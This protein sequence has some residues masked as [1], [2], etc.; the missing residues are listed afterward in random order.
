VTLA[1]RLLA[2][3][4]LA[5]LA[6]LAPAG[7]AH[8][9]GTFPSA[10]WESTPPR[11]ARERALIVWDSGTKRE[12]FVREL[13][14]SHAA[15]RFGFVIPTPSRPTVH[16][17]EKPPFDG[18][19]TS[20]PSKLFPELGFGA[21]LRLGGAGR[22]A[23]APDPPVKVLEATR[24]GDFTAFV[25][26]ATDSGALAL[27]LKKHGF[28][29]SAARQLWTDAYVRLGF[30][31][32]ALR[33]EGTKDEDQKIVSRTLRLSFD[34]PLPYYPYRE[35]G[36]APGEPGRE[37]SLWTISDV[38]LVPYAGVTHQSEWRLR[39]PFSEGVRRFPSV[40][41]LAPTLGQELGG[42]L[43]KTRIVQT[44]GD[45]KPDRRGWE[46]VVFAPLGDCS[47]AC[48]AERAAVVP[49]L[50]L[51]LAPPTGSAPAPAPA[52]SSSAG[53]AEPARPPT[54]AVP[55]PTP[56]RSANALSCAVGRADEPSGLWLAAL[57]ALFAR[58][59]HV[60][61]LRA[62]VAP[63]RRARMRLVL[64][65]LLACGC[66]RTPA[67]PA[68]P[69]APS[70]SPPASASSSALPPPE[71]T[72]P[73]DPSARR[74]AVADVLANRF[75]GYVSV[76][77]APNL[78]SI[79]AVEHVAEPP[80]PGSAELKRVCAMDIETV[81]TLEAELSARGD[82]KEA[83][84]L[85][86]LPKGTRECLEKQ[87]AGVL[88]GP[89]QADR[90]ERT[91]AYF[92][93]RILARG[94]SGSGRLPRPGPKLR[95]GTLTATEGLPVEVV[96]RVFRQRFSRVRACFES[97]PAKTTGETLVD[98]HFAIGPAGT[99]QKL[100]AAAKPPALA[101]CLTA[102]LRDLRF[103]TPRKPVHVAAKLTYS[104]R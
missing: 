78:G 33:F 3:A 51:S 20:H 98:V 4:L 80:W 66:R 103:P 92:G 42:L 17:V 34:S 63:R 14:F 35:P 104:P 94:F 99:V 5:L 23:T 11:L 40:G 90:T 45:F 95:F 81:V 73:R 16:A 89:E 64:V 38:L 93:D 74:E 85:G 46:D 36:D 59:R 55:A 67:P 43:P 10:A 8:A 100:R 44:F 84:A 37:L 28:T 48:R 7:R 83:R 62:P 6:L 29:T 96:R 25:L 71:F 70:A 15:G 31:F 26:T 58:L 102:A 56:A 52:P 77:S 2:V 91:Q 68:P 47:D 53:S 101:K 22:G 1:L 69:D 61:S 24:V 60:R 75:D 65:A 97:L 76:W 18:L 57:L 88:F 9:C 86:P 30:H 21:G 79:G 39:R 82:V 27:W 41:E 12:H 50:D 49:W 72:A 54:S 87:V 32:V 13:L 19:E